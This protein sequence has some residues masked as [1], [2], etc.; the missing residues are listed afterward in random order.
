MNLEMLIFLESEASD[1]EKGRFTY[2]I[3]AAELL[4]INRITFIFYSSIR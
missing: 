2:Y 4:L 3:I 1:Y